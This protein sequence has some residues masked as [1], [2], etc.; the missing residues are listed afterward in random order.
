MSD[1]NNVLLCWG[2]SAM[3][4]FRNTQRIML[5]LAVL[6]CVLALLSA[7]SS[8]KEDS[9]KKPT[10]TPT[11][12]AT[13]TETP[14]P[15]ATPTVTPEPPTPTPD[16]VTAAD[17]EK[18]VAAIY[19]GNLSAANKYFDPTCTLTQDI[20]DGL[21]QFIVENIR[22]VQEESAIGCSYAVYY[23]GGYDMKTG[24]PVKMY[25]TDQIWYFVITN[26]KLCGPMT[27]E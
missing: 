3:I 24:K 22:C 17:A 16:S 26:G 6:S 21:S 27:D 1:F 10:A 20:V 15:T 13:P 5:V 4:R 12:T 19:N 23:S 14:M 2:E 11:A 9:S 18:A 8:D 25:V 7:C